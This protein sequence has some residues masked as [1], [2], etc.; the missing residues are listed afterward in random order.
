MF[1]L[2]RPN[3]VDPS[4]KTKTQIE[5]AQMIKPYNLPVALYTI[6][7]QNARPYK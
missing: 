5:L 4:L 3:Q 6:Q 7:N 2:N 1:R